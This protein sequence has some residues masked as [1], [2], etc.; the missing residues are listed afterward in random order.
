MT[1]FAG[2]TQNPK[3]PIRTPNQQTRAKNFLKKSMFSTLK[4]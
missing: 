3:K 2:S 4:V 1:K